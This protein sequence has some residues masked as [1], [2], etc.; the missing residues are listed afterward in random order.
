ME[1]NLSGNLARK[2]LLQRGNLLIKLA[3]LY[4]FGGFVSLWFGTHT[5]TDS[6]PSQPPSQRTTNSTTLAATNNQ[7]STNSLLTRLDELIMSTNEQRKIIFPILL[8]LPILCF[9]WMVSTFIDTQVAEEVAE[10]L[11]QALQELNDNESSEGIKVRQELE[12]LAN[13]EQL[14]IVT[15]P[16]QL[17]LA[18][19]AKETKTQLF[20][21]TWIDQAKQ[22]QMEE[23]V[24]DTALKILE[25]V[26]N[27][28]E[29][30]LQN[31]A[32]TNEEIQHNKREEVL[33]IL[34][35]T[36]TLK[37]WG[38]SQGQL[39]QDIPA[40]SFAWDIYVF[41]KAWLWFGLK[42]NGRE[43]PVELINLS[44]PNKLQHYFEAVRQVANL[45]DYQDFDA[46]FEQDEIEYYREGKTLIKTKLE[47]LEKLLRKTYTR[48]FLGISSL[49]NILKQ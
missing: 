10:K 33:E 43:F 13:L 3:L 42:K 26:I 45:L 17:S 2:K 39:E 49:Q 47:T 46:I 14:T 6:S 22:I 34:A 16:S 20:D 4:L 9:Y 19:V 15:I 28:Q 36:A 35:R 21:A 40:K 30:T 32:L 11:Q 29:N 23:R 27:N 25:K 48:P 41:L 37:S 44:V 18:S 1:S 12:F 31:K 24:R 38:I 7:G 8:G 5:L